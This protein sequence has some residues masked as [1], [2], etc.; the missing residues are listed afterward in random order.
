[1]KYLLSAFV[2]LALLVSACGS[3]DDNT[4][5]DTNGGPEATGADAGNPTQPAP[6]GSTPNA[7]ALPDLSE[8]DP[9]APADG[10]PSV[11]GEV[12]TTSSGLQ[13]IIFEEG[14]GASPTAAQTVTVH[15]TG[16]LT[17]GTQFDSSVS[18]GQSISFELAG[19]IPGW[20]E[21]LQLVQT[22][23]KIRL[24][25]PSDLAYGPSGRPPTIPGNADLIFAVELLAVQ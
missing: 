18:R 3:D 6:G 19:V 4:N 21:G 11:E 16:W 20:T 15:Y 8:V 22:G 17:D 1:M 10:I 2:V 25:I 13:Y 5:G 14:T 12:Q 23:G 7:S 9:N 24:L